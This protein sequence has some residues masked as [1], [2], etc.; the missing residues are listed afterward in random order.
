MKKIISL[1]IF[2]VMAFASTVSAQIL[3]KVERPGNDHVTYILGTHH[4]APLT[5][6]DSLSVLPDALKNCD[7][8]YGELDMAAMSS[9]ESMMMMQQALIAP[10]D[11]TLDK[12]LSQA[13]LD[14][15]KAALNPLTGGQIPM[16]ILYPMKPAALSTQIAAMMAM[17]LFPDLNPMEG[18][19][20]TMQERA[21]ALGK[22]VGGLET[23]EFQMNALYGTPI[24]DQAESLMKT[25]GDM[26]GE[27]RRAVSLANSYLAHDLDSIL[28]LMMEEDGDAEDYERLIFSRND[29]WVKILT[30]EMPEA[31]LMVVVGAGHLPGERGVLEQL[32]KAGYTVTPAE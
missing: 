22:P 6:L 20:M 17:Q 11:S 13:Q 29:N 2:A 30:E 5:V 4:F 14:S 12:V 1:A 28:K 8:L 3:W 24:A 27:K 18:L 21:K 32:R 25:I 19:D 9:P 23:M 31:S 10:N 15:V 7:R 26:D 16:E